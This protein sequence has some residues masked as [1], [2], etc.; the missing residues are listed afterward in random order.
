MPSASKASIHPAC[1]YLSSYNTS[2]STSPK[3]GKQ[4]HQKGQGDE[5]QFPFLENFFP[6]FVARQVGEFGDK[7]EN[8]LIADLADDLLGQFG[9]YDR[10]AVHAKEGQGE[11]FREMNRSACVARNIIAV[12]TKIHFPNAN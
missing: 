10:N 9:K 7:G 12:E 2:M 11:I 5:D 8:N 6:Q 1:A 4:G 3:L